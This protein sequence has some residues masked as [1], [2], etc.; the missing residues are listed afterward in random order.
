MAQGE[1]R[2]I[3][4]ERRRSNPI[5]S[6]ASLQA[7]VKRRCMIFDCVGKEEM[8]K[9]HGKPLNAYYDLSFADWVELQRK[10][11]ES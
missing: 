11:R 8:A 10:E 6:I 7:E 9:R 5:A 1:R 2:A 4:G 3:R